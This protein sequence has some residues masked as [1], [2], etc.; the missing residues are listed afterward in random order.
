MRRTSVT[1]SRRRRRRSRQVVRGEEQLR[2]R[3]VDVDAIEFEAKFTVRVIGRTQI[4]DGR[5]GVASREIQTGSFAEGVGAH[6]RIGRSDH[7]LELGRGAVQIADDAQLR[8]DQNARA[9]DGVRVRVDLHRPAQI[10]ERNVMLSERRCGI[11]G[12]T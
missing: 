11:A 6:Q 7:R 5:P 3:R 12:D 2:Q 1:A 4:G 10:L 8:R 9:G